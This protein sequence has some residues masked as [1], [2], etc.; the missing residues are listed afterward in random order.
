MGLLSLVPHILNSNKK[1]SG[2]LLEPKRTCSDLG[3]TATWPWSY[4][5][6]QKKKRCNTAIRTKSRR[7]LE[8]TTH[9]AQLHSAC[10][11]E[12]QSRIWSSNV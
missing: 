1:I 6:L 3:L 4:P 10:S 5:E 9:N 8:Y 12:K 7:L 11:T 2:L